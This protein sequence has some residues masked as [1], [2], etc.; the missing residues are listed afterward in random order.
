TPD[1]LDELRELPKRVAILG[2]TPRACELAQ[3]FRRYGSEV[4]LVSDDERL[5]ADEEPLVA[6]AVTRA[7]AELGVRLH[8]GW[9]CTAAASTGRARSLVIAQ[10]SAQRKLIVDQIVLALPRR[11]NLERLGLAAAGIQLL[12]RD[13]RAA[14]QVDSRLATTNPRVFAVGDVCGSFR[15]P[16]ALARMCKVAVQNAVGVTRPRFEKSLVPRFVATDPEIAQLGLTR[17]AA[18]TRKIELLSWLVPFADDEAPRQLRADEGTGDADLPGL[19]REFALLHTLRDQPDRVAGATVVGARAA[20]ALALIALMMAEELPLS[21]ASGVPTLSGT[22]GRALAR[23]S[24]V[25]EQNW[26]APAG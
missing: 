11:A 18:R 1:T 25:V 12:D 4:F 14:V 21:T 9:Q 23:L 19:G 24:L 2:A 3:A 5:L 22:F 15:G 6:G 13:G 20:E 8:L 26:R 17:A 16:E 10:G 7:L